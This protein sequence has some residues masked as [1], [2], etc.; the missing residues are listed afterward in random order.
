MY[1]RTEINNSVLKGV[2]DVF[3]S[4]DFKIN[5]Y[6]QYNLERFCLNQFANYE[7]GRKNILFNIN[8]DYLSGGL[9]KLIFGNKKSLYL[10]LSKLVTISKKS[11]NNFTDMS[12][13]DILIENS[14]TKC[15]DK[16]NIATYILLSSLDIKILIDI[17][18]SSYLKILSAND[19]NEDTWVNSTNVA[20]NIGDSI[21]KE[22]FR[23]LYY[24]YKKS[25]DKDKIPSGYK[26][27]FISNKLDKHYFHKNSRFHATIG[28]KILDILSSLNLIILN[29]IR[30]NSRTESVATIEIPTNIKSL[31]KGRNVISVPMRLPMIVKPK[32]YD[33]NK[34]GGY[35]LNDEEEA[36]EL[37]IEKSAYKSPSFIENTSII[38]DIVNSLNSTGFKINSELLEFVETYGEKFGI[39]QKEPS[40]T[41]SEYKDL[42]SYKKKQ[43]LAN[44][45]KYRLQNYILEIA[46]TYKKLVIYFP[47]RLDNRG[48]FYCTPNYLNYQGSDLAR[49][50]LLFEKPGIINRKDDLSVNYLK[51]FGANCFGNG[52]DKKSFNTRVG[53]VNNN[54]HDILNYS[55]G[56]LLNK[57]DNKELF[58]SFCLEFVRYTKFEENE[59]LDKFYT[60]LPI[61]LDATCNGFQ[62]LAM[63][64]NE[65]KLF[66]HLNLSTS[67]KDE[68]PKDFYN[69]LLFLLSKKFQDIL[70]SPNSDSNTT[71]KAMRLSTFMWHRSAIKK[72]I[73]TIPYNANKRTVKQ[74]ILEKLIEVENPNTDVSGKWYKLADNKGNDHN[75]ICYQ[76]I[77][78]FVDSIFEV[79]DVEFTMIRKLIKYLK[80]VSNICS[81]LQVPISWTL[82]H[83]L[84]VNQGYL[85]VY[86]DRISIFAYSKTK[87]TLK[88]TDRNKLDSVKQC[89]ALM[90]NLI[91]SLDAASMTLL[92]SEFNKF[93]NNQCNVNIYGIHDC[94][95]TTAEKVE[96]LLTILR[97]VYVSIYSQEPYLRKF[98][99]SIINIITTN[100]GDQFKWDPDTRTLTSE[101]NKKEYILHDI[102]WIY[103]RKTLDVDQIKRIDS[104]NFIY[105]SQYI[106]N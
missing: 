20:I 46:N 17:C 61:Q 103:N 21:C 55:N 52:L 100:Y 104:Q 4:K 9:S 27:W 94:F 32:P 89:T 56:I 39:L 45:S 82:P 41:N 34:L 50:L 77:K 13:D 28:G 97:S 36:T 11:I 5:N 102:D 31:L 74:Y 91:H 54:K 44:R 68:E 90:P 24:K 76:D 1:N 29:V 65:K 64:S 37:V 14:D 73:M 71:D 30:K 58:L 47:I 99:N 43:V 86:R 96:D 84:I 92:F 53:W 49:A 48:R 85:K 101:I 10:Y 72:G 15:V 87:L 78:Y 59:I 57:A 22:Y 66:K 7:S 2:K 3:N 81:V 8:F 60:Y 51:I 63:M 70:N 83:G 62:H 75:I 23:Q 12:F 26:E 105:N 106:L 42:S 18:F 33:K 67:N 93:Y 40:V 35:L 98:D 16:S 69:Y 80:N 38:Y 25:C 88:V 95:A 19:T 79:F 6:T